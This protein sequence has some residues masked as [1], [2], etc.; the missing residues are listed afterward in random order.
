[1]RALLV[2]FMVAPPANGGLGFSAEDAGLL[3]GNYTM[4]VYMLA[5]PGGFLADRFLGAK[6]AV[7]A[8]GW[9]IALGHYALAVP[10]AATFYAGLILIALGT[11]LF[12][13]NISSLVGA[14]YDRDD[15]RRDAG[16][17][18]FYMGINVG[19]FFAPLVTGFLAQSQWFKTWLQDNGFDPAQ[20][21]HW[22]FA[23]AGIGM[24]LAMLIFAKSQRGL[25]EPPLSS[26]P[27]THPK[28][29]FQGGVVVF[30]TLALLTLAIASDRPGLQWLRWLFL[31]MPVAFIAYAARQPGSDMRRFAAI[32]VLF[33]ASMI[34]WAVFEQAG[35]TISLFSEQLTRTEVFGVPFPS[36]WFQSVNPVFVILLSPV[37]AGL[38]L[39]LGNRQPSA[40]LKFA[41]GLV[42]LAASFA[43]L[44][45]AARLAIDG[46]VSPLWVVA[47]FFLQTVGELCL[48]PSGLSTMT[49]LAPAGMA[50]LVLGVWFLA[51]AFGNK[52]AGV[53]AGSFSSTDPS[54][55]AYTFAIQAAAVAAAAFAMFLLVPW[56]N[57]LSKEA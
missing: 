29:G 44:V 3:Y 46:R 9:A 28:F 18:I 17:S 27:A 35:S 48:S 23:A 43:I 41:I 14:L 51:S 8:G 39:R 10:A 55:L 30:G 45:P 25:S 57:R 15:T 37:F 56:V 4:A 13:P 12:K 31:A 6:R 34:F 47:L 32:G 33:I 7:L 26:F 24:T 16:F 53:L 21:W 36:S 52:L 5:I 42:F 11:G 22:G 1:M 38:W 2:L 19:A 20:S 50:G 49:K 54:A 40:P